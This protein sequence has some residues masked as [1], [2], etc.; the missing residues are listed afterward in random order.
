MAY[1]LELFKKAKSDNEL[2]IGFE[3]QIIGNEKCA[4]AGHRGLYSL[5]DA[6]VVIRRKK[7]FVCIRGEGLKLENADEGEII[8]CGTIF[9]VCFI[10]EL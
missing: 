7:G 9:E 4:I 10:S 1:L 2:C 3:V 8:L 6:E 5:S